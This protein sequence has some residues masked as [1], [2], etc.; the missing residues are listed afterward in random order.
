ML[1][2]G[3]LESKRSILSDPARPPGGNGQV[4]SSSD[5]LRSPPASRGGC[6]TS[7]LGRW[8]ALGVPKEP[9]WRPVLCGHAGRPW[10][11]NPGSPDSRPEGTERGRGSILFPV[12]PWDTL[13]LTRKGAGWWLVTSDHHFYA[14]QGVTGQGVQRTVGATPGQLVFVPQVPRPLSPGAPW[15]C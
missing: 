10:Q 5:K 14:T 13:P 6:E 2:T 8:A 15:D 3:T 11:T 4:T 12:L 7:R 9:S 1:Q